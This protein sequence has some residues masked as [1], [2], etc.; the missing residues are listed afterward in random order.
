MLVNL[1]RDNPQRPPDWRWLKAS[2]YTDANRVIPRSHRDRHIWEA[3]EFAQRLRSLPTNQEEA[4][5]EMVGLSVDFPEISQAYDIYDNTG[6]N[7]FRWE[8]EA[9]ILANE[10]FE[11]ISKK[12]STS[13]AVLETYENLFFNVLDRL[14]AW[15]WVLNCVIGRSVHA[16]MTERD[17]DLLWKLYGY[18]GGPFFVDIL[19]NKTGMHEKVKPK[20]I[21][22]ALN[23]MRDSTETNATVVAAK[24]F[25]LTP[26][27]SFTIAGLIAIEQNYRQITKESAGISAAQNWLQLAGSVMSR[28][29]HCSG[30]DKINQ[31]V[32]N[33]LREKYDNT[34]AEL[35]AHEAILVANG[36]TLQGIENERLPEPE[37]KDG[38]E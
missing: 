34:P 2:K 1:T 38:N 20:S 17:Y 7:G 29:P 13:V 19:T 12:S 11:E 36:E 30:N 5:F 26:V 3:V 32:L 4:A 6:P 28:L 18:V 23:M 25:T 35:R 37:A 22:E 33:A 27:N 10:S 24:G 21:Q 9:R 31:P 14:E 15:T 16:G 8:L